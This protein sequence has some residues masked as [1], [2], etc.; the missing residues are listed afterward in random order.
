MKFDNKQLCHIWSEEKQSHGKGSNLFFEGASIYSYGKHYLAGMIHTNR[1]GKKL[2]LV[3]AERYSVT[4]RKHTS[5]IVSALSGKL[6]YVFVS[7]PG[8]LKAPDNIKGLKKALE[9]AYLDAEKKRIIKGSW[10][11]EYP[12]DHIQRALD[13]LNNYL[14]FIGRKPVKRD[15]KRINAIKKHLADKFKRFQALNTPEAIAKRKALKQAR[16]E[17]K[18]EKAILDFRQ[19]KSANLSLPFDLLRVDGS[20]VVTSRGARV[21]LDQAKSVLNKFLASQ[22]IEGETIG[23]FSVTSVSDNNGKPVIK[24]GCHNVTLE[25][26]V[27]V[28]GGF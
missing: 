18:N 8:N 5:Y 22:P 6:N 14:V 27:S 10:S 1:K 13:D 2:V 25:E 21:P 12:L 11:I 3:N 24:I 28:L 15:A 20:E 16:L 7:D 4:T 9:E 19:G 17:A 26:A 23:N